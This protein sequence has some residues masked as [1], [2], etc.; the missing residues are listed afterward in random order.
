VD[1]AATQDRKL[2]AKHEVFQDEI[3]PGTERGE[4][5]PG[6]RHQYRQHAATRAQ[7]GRGV[8]VESD[9]PFG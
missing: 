8:T 1:E 4:R 2:L 5:S 9:R 3:R 6:N 7:F